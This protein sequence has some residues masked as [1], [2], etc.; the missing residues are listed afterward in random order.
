MSR[1][2][3]FPGAG[4][5][6]RQWESLNRARTVVQIMHRNEF[7]NHMNNGHVEKE[8]KVLRALQSQ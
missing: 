7:V 6:R 8:A 4:A 3:L 2:T 5:E 1:P